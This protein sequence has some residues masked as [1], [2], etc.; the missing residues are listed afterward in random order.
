VDLRDLF[1]DLV[2]FETMLWNR[3]DLR[4][5]QECGVT[6]SALNVMMVIDR[7]PSCRVFDIA[8]A[9][10]I[11]V[12]GTSQAV[13]RLE[14]AGYCTRRANPADRRSSILDLTPA[15][16][17]TVATATPIFDDELESLLRAPLSP[18]AL[19]ELGEALRTVRRAASTRRGDALEGQR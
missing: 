11:T 10:E 19:R 6:L 9:L 5:Q 3:V 12:G 14:A 7:I 4:L 17:A 13:D 15:G 8:S 2:R 16:S 18:T 1:D